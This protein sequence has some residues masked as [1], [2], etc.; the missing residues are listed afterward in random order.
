MEPSGAVGF[1]KSCDYPLAGV[2]SGVCPECGRTFDVADTRTYARTPGVR[3]R[4]WTRRGVWALGV[5]V[6]AELIAPRRVAKLAWSWPNADGVTATSATR[7]RLVG[8]RWL[9]LKYPSWTTSVR[10]KPIEAQGL[11]FCDAMFWG[12]GVCSVYDDGAIVCWNARA[13]NDGF[14]V[15]RTGPIKVSADNLD[16]LCDAFLDSRSGAMEMHGG[17]VLIVDRPHAAKPSGK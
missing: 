7:W 17:G 12:I 6:L 5:I 13:S 10:T 9:P 15:D 3:R 16:R 1:C 14:V 11:I 2:R 4:K 8:P